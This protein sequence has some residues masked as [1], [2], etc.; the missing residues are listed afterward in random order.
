M[1]V[2]PKSIYNWYSQT[3]RNPKYR[4]WIILGSL[5]YLLSPLDISPDL[6]PIAG[7]VDD[8][9]ILTLLLTEVSQMVIDYS[10]LRKDNPTSTQA[11]QP[12]AD[13]KTVDVDSVSMD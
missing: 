7:Q 6:I 8:I 10:K 12:E 13:V 11:T 5:L 1:N 2:T 4:W 3:I 9:V